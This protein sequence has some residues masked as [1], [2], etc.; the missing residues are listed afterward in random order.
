MNCLVVEV[1]ILYIRCLN[2]RVLIIGSQH[3]GIYRR[4]STIS[5][6]LR[7]YRVL[8]YRSSRLAVSWYLMQLSTAL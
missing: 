1:Y 3:A 6:E 5:Y 8:D 7:T 2:N 4:G